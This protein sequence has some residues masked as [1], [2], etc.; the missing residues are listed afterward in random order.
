[1]FPSCFFLKKNAYY[2]EK[3][4]SKRKEGKKDKRKYKQLGEC[5]FNFKVYFILIIL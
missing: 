5:V 1:M 2:G 3:E 4:E